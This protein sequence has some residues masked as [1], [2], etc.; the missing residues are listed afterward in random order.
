MLSWSVRQCSW[1]GVRDDEPRLTGL[2]RRAGT[3]VGK[4]MTR[5]SMTT[6]ATCTA[7]ASPPSPSREVRGLI[8]RLAPSAS[9]VWQPGLATWLPSLLR[10]RARGESSTRG[11]ACARALR[12]RSEHRYVVGGGLDA[13]AAPATGAQEHCRCDT[14]AASDFHTSCKGFSNGSGRAPTA[15]IAIKEAIITCCDR[16]PAAA[17]PG[18]A[19]QG[20]A[21]V[22]SCA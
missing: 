2:R 16:P 22:E 19:C 1:Y 13:R 11:L 6:S 15:V 12:D 4:S 17:R 5:G 10:L 20:H 8:R 9:P 18:T 3:I 21:V 14:L 7:S